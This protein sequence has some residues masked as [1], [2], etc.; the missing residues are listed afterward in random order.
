MKKDKNDTVLFQNSRDRHLGISISNEFYQPVPM[1]FTR[2]GAELRVIGHYRGASAFLVGNGPSL[3]NYDLTQMKRPGVMSIGMNNGPRTFRPNF[4]C[5]VDHPERFMKSIWLD[6]NIMK[7]VPFAHFERKI[8]DNGIAWKGMD[9]MVGECP[10]VVGYR[11]NEKFMADR[12]LFEDTFNWGNHRDYGGGRSVF[13]PTLRIL[14]L[15]GFRKVYLVGVDMKMSETYAYHFDEQRDKGAVHCNNSTYDRLMNDYLPQLKPYLDAEGFKVYNCNSDSA[16]KVFPFAKFEDAIKE[17]TDPLGDI[18]NERTWGMYC[19]PGEKENW[20]DEPEDIHKR[21]LIT[22][23][24]TRITEAERK[25]LIDQQNAGG[26]EVRFV[27]GN[28]IP[29]PNAPSRPPVIQM[30]PQPPRPPQAQSIPTRVIRE[31]VEVI[32]QAPR[33]LAPTDFT[34]AH[35]GNVNGFST[36][37]TLPDE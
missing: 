23:D 19:K 6:P 30:P 10:N 25:R 17:M 24:P 37:I 20:K 3:R 34:S 18:A 36:H 8:F 32:K 16:L 21:H 29:Q 35:G 14:F 13:L 2:E 15:L 22:I 33:T 11:R 4:W 9:K 31:N 1:F 27:V 7:F 5:C 28:S 12:F 26:P